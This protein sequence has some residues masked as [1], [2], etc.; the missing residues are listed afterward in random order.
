M[1]TV[2]HFPS[3]KSF[4]SRWSWANGLPGIAEGKYFCM[5]LLLGGMYASSL[6]LNWVC[7][8]KSECSSLHIHLCAFYPLGLCA[9]CGN[10]SCGHHVLPRA[11]TSAVEWDWEDFPAGIHLIRNKAKWQSVLT[12][13]EQIF[14]CLKIA[15][16]H[17]VGCV[18]YSPKTK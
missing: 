2:G 5:Y 16:L 14:V 18:D 1:R 7:R 12:T 4:L 6:P 17:R 3:K 13:V 15:W 10:L 9:C 11:G 8:A